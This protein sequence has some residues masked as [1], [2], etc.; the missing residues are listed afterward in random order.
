[1]MAWHYLLLIDDEHLLKS[2]VFL[3]AITSPTYDQA[4]M[5]NT[6]THTRVTNISSVYELSSSRDALMTLIT[7]AVL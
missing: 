2:R 7:R 4:V 1:M 6:C 3:V 5:N